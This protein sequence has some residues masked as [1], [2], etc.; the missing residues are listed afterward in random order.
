MYICYMLLIGLFLQPIFPFSIAASR[1]VR[2]VEPRSRISGYGPAIGS[3]GLEGR[4]TANQQRII[5]RTLATISLWSTLAIRA[6]PSSQARGGRMAWPIR[7]AFERLFG[8]YNKE[9]R[10]L[11]RQRFRLL[12]QESDRSTT[13]VG[14]LLQRAK[15]V[16]NC[17]SQPDPIYCPESMDL[18]D[19]N[20]VFRHMGR[21][22]IVL[23]C[24][25]YNKLL[26]FWRFHPLQPRSGGLCI[27]R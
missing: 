4:C 3:L 23:V 7:M 22:E 8:S 27:A 6:T 12:K 25:R 1:G 24:A 19:Y 14:A 16:I 2:Y 26:A 5:R 21:N 17:R 20:Q 15:V 11:V 10:N 9:N 18:S 13:A